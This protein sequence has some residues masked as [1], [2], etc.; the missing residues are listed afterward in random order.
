MLS[1]SL[2]LSCAI[3]SVFAITPPVL[4]NDKI[5]LFAGG[6]QNAVNMS[7][8]DSKLFEPFGAE[9]DDGGN[10]WI[11]E[12]ASGNRLLKV[13]TKHILTH[14]AG[15]FYSATS[16]LATE[17]QGDA[18]PGLQALFNGP[19]N[20]AVE[21]SRR[22]LI[23][24]TWNGRIRVVDPQSD[25]VSSLSNYQVPIDKAK[26]SGPYCISLDPAKKKLYVADLQRIHMLDL[27]TGTRSIIAGNGKK[28][29]PID[30]AVATE[31]PLS[32]PRAVAVDKNGN[33]YILE[34]G[35]NALRVVTTDGK[36]KTVVNASGKKGISS[37]SGPALDALLNGPKHLCIDEANRVVIADAENHI[38][39]RYDPIDQT[40]KRIAGTGKVGR[41]GIGGDPLACQLARP[42]GVSVHPKTGELYITDSYNHRILRI[43]SSASE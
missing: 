36:I 29:P 10:L 31:S 6:D 17:V 14:V 19:H 9:F 12:M 24:D 22:L 7:A 28:G 27:A 33:V 2:F 5:V 16:S 34:R 40:V 15:K 20:L 42:H 11:L 39:V 38:V 41:D 1:K 8:L 43:V 25:V 32:D 37:P 21:S 4:S 26:S 35:G 30:G 18:G 13:D 3:V 23:A